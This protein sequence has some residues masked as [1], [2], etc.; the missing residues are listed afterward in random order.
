MQLVF[1]AGAHFTEEERLMKC[2]LRNK[3]VMSEHGI[4]VPGP[5]KYRKLLRQTFSALSEGAPA[6]DAAEILLDAI[7]DGARAQRVVMSNAHLF[8]PPLATIRQ[9]VLCRNAP[10]RVAQLAQIFHRQD[11]EIFLAV[12]NPATYLPACVRVAANVSVPEVLGGVDP[13]DI[14]WSDTVERIR[15]AAPDVPITLWCNEDAPLLWA[16][17]IREI[18]GVEQAVSMTGDFDLLAEIMSEDGMVAFMDHLNA[19][20]NMPQP[21]LRNAM[22][23]F[24]EK[25]VLDEEI[26]EE[27]DVP[28]WTGGLVDELSDIYDEDMLEIAGFPGIRVLSP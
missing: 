18:A 5:G 14:R 26:E 19:D 21:Q 4:A 24:L 7:L 1:H 12:R 20:P 28:G 27:I 16:Q 9:G 2:L 3:D 22:V 17:I 13:R 8:G 11:V 10:D 6:G 25:Y 15:A 23:S